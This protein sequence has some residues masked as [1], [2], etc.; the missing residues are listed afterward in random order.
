MPLAKL[1]EEDVQMEVSTEELFTG[2]K[3]VIEKFYKLYNSMDTPEKKGHYEVL[4][5]YGPGGIGKSS[6]IKKICREVAEKTDNKK[7]PNYAYF[8]FEGNATKEEFMFSLSRQMKRYNNDLK[9]FFFDTAMA[10]IVAA[11]GQS[12]ER[13]TRQQMDWR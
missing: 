8:S 6:V 3:D 1:L 11:E 4:L 13:Y 2:R 10:K 5:F 12:L 9:F 7:V